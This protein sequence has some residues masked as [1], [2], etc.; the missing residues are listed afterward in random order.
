MVL[1]GS[2]PQSDIFPSNLFLEE[3]GE[4]TL[5]FLEGFKTFSAKMIVTRIPT[6]VLLQAF[7]CDTQVLPIPHKPLSVLGSPFLPNYLRI[8]QLRHQYRPLS[9]LRIVLPKWLPLSQELIAPCPVMRRASAQAQ[10]V[11]PTALSQGVLWKSTSV[12]KGLQEI[13]WGKVGSRSKAIK[14]KGHA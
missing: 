14:D 3:K 1:A 5:E 7:C 11:C 6:S 8:L 9:H 10:P 4:M 2:T 13:P 12:Q